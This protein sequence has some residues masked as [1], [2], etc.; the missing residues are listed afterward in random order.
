MVRRG[1][2]GG[3]GRVQVG[4]IGFVCQTGHGLKW[5]IFKRVNRVAG[6]VG[7]S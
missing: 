2:T 1:K 7:S 6:R 3:S 5:V 4:S